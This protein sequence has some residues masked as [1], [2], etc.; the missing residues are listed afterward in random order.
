MG[1][2]ELNIRPS[3]PWDWQGVQAPWPMRSGVGAMGAGTRAT[4]GAPGHLVLNSRREKVDTLGTP[5]C[6][7]GASLGHRVGW[8]YLQRLHD[9]AADAASPLST[10]S[11]LSPETWGRVGGGSEGGGN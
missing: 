2:L 3:L 11:S 9:D 6:G 7:D 1:M 4:P 5:G 10:R 8:P